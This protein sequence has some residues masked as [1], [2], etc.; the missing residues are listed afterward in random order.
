ME[1]GQ[2]PPLLYTPAVRL[3]SP[4]I[5]ALISEGIEGV[6]MQLNVTND[7]QTPDHFNHLPTVGAP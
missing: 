4:Q 2:L 7:R 5:E 6:S 3:Y 1:G